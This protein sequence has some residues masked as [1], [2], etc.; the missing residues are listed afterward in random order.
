MRKILITLTALLALV[1]LGLPSFAGEPRPRPRRHS[2]TLRASR[3]LLP[4]RPNRALLSE[5]PAVSRG[6]S[7]V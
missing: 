5:V 2:S 1:I 7:S 3:Y 6:L 4:Q